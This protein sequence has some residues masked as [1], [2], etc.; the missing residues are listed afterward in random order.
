MMNGSRASVQ[1][2]KVQHAELFRRLVVVTTSSWPYEL[3]GVH[4]GI[5][6]KEP[7]FPQPEQT[8]FK[9][10]PLSRNIKTFVDFGLLLR[11]IGFAYSACACFSIGGRGR[12]LSTRSD[13]RGH[14]PLLPT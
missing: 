6:K 1:I 3:I 11:Y 10:K 9:Q 2:A 4:P 7:C 12:H 8:I 14:L 5:R 13:W